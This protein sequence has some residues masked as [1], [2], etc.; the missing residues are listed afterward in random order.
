MLAVHPCRTSTK[1]AL[2]VL[3]AAYAFNIIRHLWMQSSTPS[4]SLGQI[5]LS[6]V[7]RHLVSISSPEAVLSLFLAAH[8]AKSVVVRSKLMVSFR[9]LNLKRRGP[10]SYEPDSEQGSHYS[11][12]LSQANLQ[13]FSLHNILAHFLLLERRFSQRFKRSPLQL[14]PSFVAFFQRFCRIL[15]SRMSIPLH[16]SLNAPQSAQWRCSLKVHRIQE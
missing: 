9:A 11:P 13:E 8:D 6:K 2:E 3:L 10:Q 16:L 4:S 1:L 5:L 14:F 7:C 12:S 15:C